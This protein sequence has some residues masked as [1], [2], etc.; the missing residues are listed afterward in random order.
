MSAKKEKKIAQESVTMFTPVIR[1]ANKPHKCDGCGECP[2]DEGDTYMLSKSRDKSGAFSTHR[3]CIRCC[4]AIEVKKA[5]SPDGNVAI[6]PGDLKLSKLS[7]KFRKTWIEM[8]RGMVQ[9]QK[10]HD[11]EGARRLGIWFQDQ[12]GISGIG[13]SKERTER[14]MSLVGASRERRKAARAEAREL[15]EALRVLVDEIHALADSVQEGRDEAAKA[16]LA[17]NI[18]VQKGDDEGAVKADERLVRAL[19]ALQTDVDLLSG[20]AKKRKKGGE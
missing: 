7:A 15:R 20:V 1:R 14:V 13:A 9:A 18:A 3:Y 12:M 11:N 5:N 10:E 6:A 19:N 16:R 4:L 8:A 2:I 17:Y